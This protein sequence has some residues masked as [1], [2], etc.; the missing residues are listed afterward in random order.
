MQHVNQAFGAAQALDRFL[1]AEGR[2]FRVEPCERN[3]RI[4]SLASSPDLLSGSTGAPPFAARE[5]V[6]ALTP[7]MS[8]SVRCGI[9]RM[10]AARS[11]AW[12]RTRAGSV[13]GEGDLCAFDHM[14]VRPWL[15]ALG[16]ISGIRCICKPRALDRCDSLA[17]RSAGR[18]RRKPMAMYEIA[19]QPKN[20]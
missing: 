9:S 14:W 4:Q 12:V 7:M 5:T 16:I 3:T 15:L 6:E 20:Q 19:A 13:P 11:A 10:S 2:I 1:A 17:A 18:N 8:A